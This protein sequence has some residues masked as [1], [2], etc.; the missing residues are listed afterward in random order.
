MSGR[1][2]AAQKCFTSS[3]MLCLKDC[4]VGARAWGALHKG[5]LIGTYAGPDSARAKPV[6]PPLHAAAPAAPCAWRPRLF[7][8]FLNLVA[9]FPLS[10]PHSSIPHFAFFSG[11]HSPFP[12]SH[13]LFFPRPQ[14]R[15]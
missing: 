10:Q 1:V 15:R 2:P 14:A 5:P 9:H 7:S 3:F 6:L 13:G 8:Y 12:I 11:A 4:V